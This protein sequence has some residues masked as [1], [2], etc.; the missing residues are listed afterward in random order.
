MP[1]GRRK[2]EQ[3]ASSTIREKES[4]ERKAENIEEKAA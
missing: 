1:C 3:R 2:R 4:G